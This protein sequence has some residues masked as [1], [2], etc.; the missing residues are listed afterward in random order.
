MATPTKIIYLREGGF[1]A[2][3]ASD[4]ATFGF[5]IGGAWF[6]HQ[7]IGGSYFVNAILLVMFL[8]F[9][10]GKAAAKKEIFYSEE[11]LLTRLTD[12]KR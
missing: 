9:L 3:V 5:F 7:F 2:S 8:L 11:E 12:G 10:M 1:L 6:N 4:A